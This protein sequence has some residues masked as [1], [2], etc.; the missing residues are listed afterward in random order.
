[1]KKNNF[2]VVSF[3]SILFTSGCD[4]QS[5]NVSPDESADATLQTQTAKPSENNQF[6]KVNGSQFYLN[7]KPY[8]FLGANVW[9]GAYLGSTNA[10]YGDRLPQ[11]WAA[12]GND[13]VCRQALGVLDA[14]CG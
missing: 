11:R 7:D 12:R 4:K 3:I 13:S 8:A 2:L 6:V 10:D 1:M 9:Y 14:G 5:S